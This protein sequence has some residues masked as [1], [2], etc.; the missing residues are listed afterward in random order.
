M[1]TTSLPLVP[2]ARR[3]RWVMLGVILFDLGNGILGQP[4]SY[5]RNP[6]TGDAGNRLF[7]FFL[8]LGPAAWFAFMAAY[9]AV[10]F[11]LASLRCGRWALVA[12]FGYML[13]H[14]GSACGWLIWRWHLGAAGCVVASIAIAWIIAGLVAGA[15]APP[16]DPGSAGR[17]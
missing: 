16:A 11:L 14:F 2:I 4:A 7:H 8:V 10:A 3:L 17:A 9:V 5:W 13:G 6:A 12:I 1:E 15:L